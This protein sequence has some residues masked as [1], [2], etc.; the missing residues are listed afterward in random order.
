MTSC[1]RK[2]L[3]DAQCRGIKDSGSYSV[4]FGFKYLSVELGFWIQ[5]VSGV[6]DSLSC[7]PVS[8]AHKQNFPGFGIPQAKISRIL[9]C[10]C[11]YM[12]RFNASFKTIL[13]NWLVKYGLKFCFLEKVTFSLQ[14]QREW[15]HL[16][17]FTWMLCKTCLSVF[18]YWGSF[19]FVLS[20]LGV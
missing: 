11:H 16:L 9:E 7:I 6:P 12:G 10:E 20:V 8:E 15:K 19:I 2:Q 1:F 4:D 17:K 13:K 18:C 14:I 5:N 3:S